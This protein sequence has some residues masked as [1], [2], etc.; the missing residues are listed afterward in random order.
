MSADVLEV[1]PESG[2]SLAI[3]FAIVAED[4][5]RRVDE[6]LKLKINGPDDKAG[7]KLCDTKRKEW[8]KVRT[9]IDKRKE[10]L[11][12]L[13]KE[14]IKKVN[15]VAGDLKAIAAKAEDHVTS[16]V[17]R[18]DAEIA[19][20][21]RDKIEAAFKAKNDRLVAAGISLPRILVD[22]MSD[23]DIDD[24][25]S[26]AEELAIFRKQQ[27]EKEAVAKAE[28]ERK[29]AEQAE[30]NRIEAERLAAERAEF[31]RQQAA[32]K[33][34]QDRLSKIEADKLAAE[35]A[36]LDRRKAEQE[37]AARLIR[38][39]QAEAQRQIDEEAARL[40]KINQDRIDAALAEQRAAEKR[41][42]DRIEADEQLRR[43]TEAARLKAEQAEADRVL[44]EVSKP[45]SEK[46]A[47]V[48]GLLTAM[49]A[50]ERVEVFLLFCTHCGTMNPRCQCCNDE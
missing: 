6:D 15:G 33:A 5:Q 50:E 29:A 12:E 35:R 47:A 43:E 45:D 4:L 24:K 13:A 2:L 22:S 26:E 37:E 16:E 39:Q 18:I 30:A 3:D 25:I 46:F 19:K 34:E 44:A 36:E 17:D 38:E 10:H 9:G 49:T 28:A 7:Y 40:E 11:N 1:K 32:A 23:I 42:H 20:A 27:A 8:V 21:E 48:V 31:A 14:H 41:E